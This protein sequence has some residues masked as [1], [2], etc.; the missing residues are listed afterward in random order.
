MPDLLLEV[1]SQTFGYREFRP[2]QRQIIEATLAGRD[3][4]AL[5]PTGGGKSLCFQLPALIRNGLTVVVSPLIALMKDQVDQLQT[6][7]IAATFLNST[8]EVGEAR[9]RLRRLHQGEYCLLY[10]APERLMLDDWKGNLRAWNVKA[11]VIDEAHCISEWGH[12]FRPE[13]RQLRDLRTLL[14]EVPTLALTAT[15]TPRVRT[16]II[17]H[18]NLNDPAVFIAS[19]NRPNLAYQVIPKDQPLR[20][21]LD[22]AAK[23]GEESGIVYCA[24]RATTERLAA[25]LAARG[26]A[27]RPYHAGLPIEVRTETQELFLRDEVHIICATIA[28]GMGINKPNVRWVIHHD[29]PR[30]LEAYYQETG[31]AGRDGLPGDCLLLFSAGDA[32]KQTHFIKE[33]STAQEQQVA[34][35]QLREMIHYAES[36]ACRRH[37][38]LTYFGEQSAPRCDAC[39]NCLSPRDS[40]NGTTVSQKFLSCVFRIRQSSQLSTGMNHIIDVLTG[41]ST[42]KVRRWNH[43]AL[44]TYGIGADVDRKEWAAIGREL[45]RQGY[46]RQAGNEFPVVEITPSGLSALRSRQIIMLA[47]PMARPKTKP[48][49]RRSGEIECDQILFDRLRTLR[50]RLADE[51]AVPAYVI[52]GDATL[53]EMARRYP[54]TKEALAGIFGVGQRKLQEFGD[55]FAAEIV[56]HLQAQPRVEFAARD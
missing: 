35:R 44:S 50:K 21:I 17:N 25:S 52:F 19:F 42:E 55:A 37:A 26:L 49:P 6:S 18:L 54:S 28:F 14:P 13:Y 43:D 47:R 9:A 1:L 36:S 16:E 31:R 23:R 11:L 30:N 10:A 5:L 27:T 2:L 46:L 39:D 8:L 40:Y 12:D 53:R 51:R 3:V 56:T 22:F 24:T 32:A 45:L 15:A 34:R 4:F 29:L 7:G 20:Q 38:L 48:Q 41:A 33:M